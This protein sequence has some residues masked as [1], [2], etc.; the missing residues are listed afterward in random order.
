[1][2]DETGRI[3]A[4]MALA[5]QYRIVEMQVENLPM[6]M[7]LLNRVVKLV[8][9]DGSLRQLSVHKAWFA[10][11]QVQAAQYLWET[12]RWEWRERGNTLTFRY[13][14]HSPLKNIFKTPPWIPES[15]F[16]FAI[17]GPVPVSEERHIASG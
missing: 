15:S 17:D 12:L 1:V 14:P 4:G 3:Q 8:P 11:E 16:T 10:S 7:R 2:E 5:E 13:D 9:P 6:V